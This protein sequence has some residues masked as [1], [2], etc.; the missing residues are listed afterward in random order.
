[1]AQRNEERMQGESCATPRSATP[2]P[3]MDLQEKMSK[4]NDN[5]EVVDMVYREVGYSGAKFNE[6]KREEGDAQGQVKAHRERCRHLSAGDGL[7]K[8]TQRK[9]GSYG[10]AHI[11]FLAGATHALSCG[12]TDR[13]CNELKYVQEA[14]DV[15]GDFQQ[16]DTR[17]DFAAVILVA[18]PR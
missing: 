1:M 7:P 8:K 5:Q 18:R 14:L 11:R 3:L 17:R 13:D 6:A 10:P 9:L 12:T 2:V 4:V 16:R 15:I